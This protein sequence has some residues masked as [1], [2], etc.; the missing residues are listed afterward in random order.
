MWK[1]RNNESKVG[2]LDR[3][4]IWKTVGNSWT[5]KIVKSNKDRLL[6]RHKRYHMKTSCDFARNL[7]ASKQFLTVSRLFLRNAHV[8]VAKNLEGLLFFVANS[9][10]IFPRFRR[11]TFEPILFNLEKKQT[12]PR[13]W[14]I[15]RL[16]RRLRR[17]GK[18]TRGLYESLGVTSTA[19]TSRYDGRPCGYPVT[20]PGTGTRPDA[21]DNPQSWF[22]PRCRALF[23]VRSG[24]SKEST[25][26]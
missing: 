13:N 16:R 6:K 18:S 3:S 15:R 12:Y 1:R 19:G 11:F 7:S 22:I 10:P 25:F 20:R 2:R 4:R 21:S 14:F 24:V 26:K 5:Y 9:F 8:F 17:N 23:M